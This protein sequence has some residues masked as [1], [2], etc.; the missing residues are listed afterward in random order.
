MC[1]DRIIRTTG[2]ILALTLAACQQ[3]SSDEPVTGELL[4]ATPPEGW[5]LAYQ[6]NAGGTR[7]SEFIPADEDINSWQT[8]LSFESHAD[9]ADVDPI[10]L[11]E[12]E[13][14]ALHDHCKFVRH[15]NV[16]SGLENNYPTSSRLVMC[17]ENKQTGRGEVSL[18]KAIQAND[19]MYTIRFRKRVPA[20]AVNQPDFKDQE[21]A[22]WTVF[23]KT[24]QVC[25]THNSDHPCR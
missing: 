20:F 23:L 18:Y 25:D 10:L 1:R 7:L 14:L 12:S 3:V 21:M 13:A 9:L 5:Q 6:L 2:L 22:S 19:F 11:L 16:Y 15:F 8:K 24:L 4:Q 17:G